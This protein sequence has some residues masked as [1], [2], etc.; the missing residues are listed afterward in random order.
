VEKEDQTLDEK[1][2]PKDGS[3]EPSRVEGSMVREI[4]GSRHEEWLEE[5]PEESP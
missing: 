2:R 3:R 5:S 1:L 4:R